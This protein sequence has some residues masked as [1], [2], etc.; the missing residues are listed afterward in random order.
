MKI[1]SYNVE[2]M[3][4]RPV[5]LDDPK[6]GK[7]N[8]KVLEAY[9]RLTDL[10]EQDSYAG[11][12]EEILRR[13]DE[14]GLLKS[15]ENR[16]AVM[17]KI[18]GSLLRHPKGKPVEVGAKGRADWAGW[19]ELK[20]EEVRAKATSNTAAVIADLNPDVLAVVEAE[21]RMALARFNE[22]VLAPLIEDASPAWDFSHVM[23]VDGNDERG[24]DVGVM[25]R[26][27]FDIT[28]IRSHIDDEK[29]GKRTFSRDCPEY[30]IATP[31]GGS[32]LLLVN[33]FK[34]KGYR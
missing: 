20:R 32:L 34:S 22:Y 6:T 15:E 18:R 10:L 5:A 25:T 26:E 14:L 2:N 4:R 1:A 7:A 13:L 8:R 21:D 9:A 12:E 24:I 3:F 16:F 31:D 27:G 17:R 29:E 28:G 11:S 30:E 33:H 19:I 23:L